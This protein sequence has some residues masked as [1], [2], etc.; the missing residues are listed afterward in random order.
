VA[1]TDQSSANLA[2]I[3]HFLL[4]YYGPQYWWPAD[5]A[6]EIMVGA[7]LTQNTSWTNVELA[8]VNLRDKNDFGFREILNLEID[9]LETLI[10]PAGF[11]RR[12]ARAIQSLCICLENYQGIEGLSQINHQECRNVLLDISGIGAETADSILLYALGKP[13]FVIDKYTR[14]ILSRLGFMD[15]ACS[16]QRFQQLFM[17]QITPDLDHYQEYHALLVAHAKKHCRKKPDCQACPLQIQCEHF[18]Q[19]KV[20]K[21]GY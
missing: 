3:Y 11:F 10:R 14:R 9:D 1:N 7:V 5:H 8:L 18:R 13:A 17:Q 6:F 19:F 12:K 4:D 16:Y 15:S 21:P 2:E 20:D